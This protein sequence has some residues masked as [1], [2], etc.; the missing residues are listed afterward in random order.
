[1]CDSLKAWIDAHPATPPIARGQR[2]QLTVSVSDMER[3]AISWLAYH[4][5]MSEVT[6]G[7]LS[8]LIRHALAYYIPAV[9]AL[10]I[11]GYRPLITQL[12]ADIDATGLSMT[13]E[14]IAAYFDVRGKE[15]NMLLTLGKVTEAFDHYAAVLEFVHSRSPTWI[16]LLLRLIEDHAQI[17]EFRERMRALGVE[18]EIRL[19]TLEDSY[20]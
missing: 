9:S 8:E 18:E 1:M 11:E 14:Q 16:G 10:M 20:A 15:L 12:R 2:R 5:N 6:H 19:R 17:T 13:V 7:E 4:P 3:E